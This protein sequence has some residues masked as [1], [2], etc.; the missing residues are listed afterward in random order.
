MAD[1]VFRSVLLGRD[2]AQ[3]LVRVENR[4]VPGEDL[5][6]ESPRDVVFTVRDPALGVDDPLVEL[7]AVLGIGA[8][9]F[10]LVVDADAAPAGQVA[11]RPQL[12]DGALVHLGCFPGRLLAALDAVP[13]AAEGDGQ[14][15]SPIRLRA[16]EVLLLGGILRDVVQL[17]PRGIDELEA[18]GAERPERGPSVVQQRV[19]GLGVHRTIPGRGPPG[20]Q[21]REAPSVDL[22]GHVQARQ[23]EDR[24]KQVDVAHRLVH[25]TPRA[26][27]GGEP[28]DKGDANRGVVHEKTVEGLAV[29]LEPLPV[30]AGDDDQRAIEES[31][32]VESTPEVADERVGVGHLGVVRP[33]RIARFEGLLRRVRI[34]GVV[35][36]EPE[37][38]RAAGGPFVEPAHGGRDGLRA[39]APDRPHVR[40]VRLLQSPQIEVVEVMVEAATDPPSAVEHEGAHEAAGGPSALAE[41]LGERGEAPVENGADVLADAV[42]GRVEAGQDRRVRRE[43][44]GHRARGVREADALFRERVDARCVDRFRAIARKTVGPEGVESDQDDVGGGPGA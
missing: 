40:P 42:A 8:G 4:L 13:E 11:E 16:V 12:G 2:L 27:A 1:R 14:V 7:K 29:V 37:K 15:P 6:Q 20:D 41:Q 31:A 44:Q 9:P 30:I 34:V 33:S 3:H 10:V 17:G 36:V 24:G 43:G 32:T 26:V 22:L 18:V 23:L 5:L 39:V 35:E 38:E 25:D 21:R 19:Q 28:D